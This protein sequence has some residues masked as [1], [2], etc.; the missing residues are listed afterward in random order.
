MVSAD[1]SSV[2]NIGTFAFHA[3][4]ALVSVRLSDELKVIDRYAFN[5][6]V[7]LTDVQPLFPDSLEEIGRAAFYCDDGMP[8]GGD[9]RMA[10]V[11]RIC[12]AAFYRCKFTSLYLPSVT[13]VGY[14]VF[15]S[16]PATNVVFGTHRVCFEDEENKPTSSGYKGYGYQ[17]FFV[18]SSI[19]RHFR[20]PGLAPYLPE[21]TAGSHMTGA[22]WMFGKSTRGDVILHGSW[23]IDPEGWQKIRDEIGKPASEV[24]GRTPPKLREGDRSLK[25]AFDWYGDGTSIGT[26]WLFDTKMPDEPQRGGYLL[27]R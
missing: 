17:T 3:A 4:K 23:R 18:D 2:T 13:N 11:K 8:I 12:Y 22:S 21:K 20:F 7:K 10:G 16:S 27:L 5:G 26:G 9:A 19:T 15:Y 6:A 25:G 24:V 1:L 14:R